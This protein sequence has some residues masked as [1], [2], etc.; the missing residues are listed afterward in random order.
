M[1][2]AMPDISM[3]ADHRCPLRETCYRYTAKP[4]D[5]WQRSGP[6]HLLREGDKCDYYWPVEREDGNG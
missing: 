3:C 1:A 5:R 2:R 6:F 4:T